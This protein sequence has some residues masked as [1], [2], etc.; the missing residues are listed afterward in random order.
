MW[1]RNE[2]NTLKLEVQKLLEVSI[3]TRISNTIGATPHVELGQKSGTECEMEVGVPVHKK[4]L[5][6]LFQPW[7]FG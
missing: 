7:G 2:T 3:P 4:K 6:K 5:K 1:T